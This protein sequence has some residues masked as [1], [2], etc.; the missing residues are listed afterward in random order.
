MENGVKPNIQFSAIV[1]PI[2]KYFAKAISWEPFVG[3]TVPEMKTIEIDWSWWKCVPA[4]K[5][6]EHSANEIRTTCYEIVGHIPRSNLF[7]IMDF[8][9]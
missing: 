7:V 9:E 6:P 2:V 1:L 8:I 5:K 4:G 3:R